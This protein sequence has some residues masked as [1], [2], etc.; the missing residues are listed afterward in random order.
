M[1]ISACNNYKSIIGNE[2]SSIPSC[3]WGCQFDNFSEQ[4]SDYSVLSGT[5]EMMDDALFSSSQLDLLHGNLNAASEAVLDFLDIEASMRGSAPSSCQLCSLPICFADHN[6]TASSEEPQ[7]ISAGDSDCCS[8]LE[9]RKW[10]WLPVDSCCSLLMNSSSLTADGDFQI[11]FGDP[12]KSKKGR[13]ESGYQPD[14]EGMAQLKEMIYKAAALRPVSFPAEA[15]VEKPKRKNVRISSDPQ[16]VAARQRRERISERLRVLQRLVPGGSNLDTAS[17]LDEAA[18]YLKFLKTQVSSLEKI[19]K[20]GRSADRSSF[21]TTAFS[22]TT[23]S[24]MQ[25]TLFQLPN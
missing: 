12:E 16:T 1:D 22:L 20:G 19:G 8:I 15:P 9:R 13:F 14:A 7:V 5:F 18:N 4:S 23:A 2:I 17:M 24:P 25:K 6:F 21:P 11:S 10:K 3:I